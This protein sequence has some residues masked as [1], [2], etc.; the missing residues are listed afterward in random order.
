[1]AALKIMRRRAAPAPR[2]HRKVID[3]ESF[4]SRAFSRRAP[5]PD[6]RLAF[7]APPA[8]R[9]EKGSLRHRRDFSIDDHRVENPIV[10]WIPSIA[11][12][13]MTVYTGERFPIWRGNVFSVP[14]A[15]AKFRHRSLERIA[16][17]SRT[18]EL[19]RESMLGELRPRIREMRQRP[20]GYL[21]LLTDQDDGA[22]LRIEPA[23]LRRA[24]IS[25]GPRW[26]SGTSDCSVQPSIA[27][28]A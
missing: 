3:F 26:A 1:M 12:A 22:L 10:V 23:Q 24:E 27:N 11:V 28:L 16:F 9:V 6:C 15:P 20:D 18:E 21:C 19:R 13:A 7:Q 2:Q 4:Y 8:L 5:Q 17:N 14:C 25:A